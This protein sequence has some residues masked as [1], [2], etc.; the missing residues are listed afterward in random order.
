MSKPVVRI[1]QD[2]FD[3]SE[4]IG[5]LATQDDNIGAVVSFV[6][7]CRDENGKLSA[8]ELEHYPG[9][10]EAEISRISEQAIKRFGLTA[11]TAVHRFG[12]IPVG[13]NIVLVI[14][15]S[16]HRR[17]AFDGAQFIMD[18]LK[19]NAPFWKKEHKLDGTEGDWV[20]ARQCDDEAKE[21]WGND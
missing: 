20:E 9:M 21:R 4:E 13:G 19:S 11:V 17:S 1:Q 16:R 5:K 12:K 18:Y 2:D 14:A 3:V 6:G 7:L 10:A 8:L 15:A